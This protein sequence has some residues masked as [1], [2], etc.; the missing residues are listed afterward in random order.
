MGDRYCGC[1]CGE[2]IAFRPHH[3]YYGLPQFV[4]GHNSRVRPGIPCSKEKKKKISDTKKGLFAQGLLSLSGVAQ[5]GDK[6]WSRTH[7]VWNRGL[8]GVQAGEKSPR[9]RGGITSLYMQVRN[10]D[11]YKEWK[12]K[13]FKRDK[14]TCIKCGARGRLVKLNA[15]HL[16]PFALVLRKNHISSLKDALSCKE[17]WDPGNGTTLCVSCHRNIK[18]IEGGKLWEIAIL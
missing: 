9:W 1:G 5:K 8:K 12:I 4:S 18:K 15:H 16:T 13:V 3:K 2:N 14:K 10:S 11:I 6:N 7:S 17:L